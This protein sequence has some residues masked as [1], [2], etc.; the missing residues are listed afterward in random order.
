MPADT[1]DVLVYG[2]T[3]AGIAAAVAAADD[4]SSVLLVES[5][6]RIGGLTAPSW[7]RRRRCS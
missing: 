7:S 4:G 1:F 3:P 5:T 2:A 6:A